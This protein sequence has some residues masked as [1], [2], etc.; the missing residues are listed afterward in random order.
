MLIRPLFSSEQVEARIDDIA[1]QL[2]RDYADSPPTLLCID[3][4]ARRFVEGLVD[5]LG[6]MRLR[7]DVHHVRARRTTGTTLSP[8]QVDGFDISV[9]D[10][11]DVLIVDDIADEGVTLKAIVELTA[12]ADV[13]SL[14]KAVLIDKRARRR[15]PVR[16]DY[17]GFEIDAG[18]VVGYGM[19]IDGEFRDLDEIGVVSDT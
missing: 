14:R 11:R 2:Y 13:R 15:E 12:L 8:V 5:R 7:C 10:G 6:R 9:L 1:R 17:V 16:L 3:I 4:G 19:D 18:W